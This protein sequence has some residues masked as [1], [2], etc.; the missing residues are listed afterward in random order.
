MLKNYLKQEC[1]TKN[2]NENTQEIN[3]E[4]MSDAIGMKDE[5]IVILN[6]KEC[7]VQTE[8]MLRGNGEEAYK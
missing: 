4:E 2:E 3:Q 1:E 5:L 6:L 8:L 7:F